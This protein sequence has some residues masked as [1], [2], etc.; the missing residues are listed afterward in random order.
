M[1]LDGSSLILLDVIKIISY[2]LGLSLYITAK[3]VS[4]PATSKYVSVSCNKFLNLWERNSLLLLQR[5]RFLYSILCNDAISDKVAQNFVVTNESLIG[6]KWKDRVMGKFE[7]L[8]RNFPEGSE[9]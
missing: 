2:C 5:I 4:V 6:R 3:A 8:P 1:T 9:D 7:V